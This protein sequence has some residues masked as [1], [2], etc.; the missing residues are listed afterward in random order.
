ME[1]RSHKWVYVALAVVIVVLMI[2]GVALWREQEQTAEARAKAREFIGKLNAAGLKAPSEETVV[3][4]FGVDGG[5]YV[6]NLREDLQ[7]AQY[8]WQ[9]GTAGPAGRPIILDDDFVAAVDAFVRVYVADKAAASD[10][11]EWLHQLKTGETTN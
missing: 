10:F 2:A 4:L 5:P 7:Q 1:E 8:A 9:L 6:Q 3:R 11:I